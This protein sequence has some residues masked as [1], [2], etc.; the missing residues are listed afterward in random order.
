MTTKGTKPSAEKSLGLRIPAN[1]RQMPQRGFSFRVEDFFNSQ[2]VA[3]VNPATGPR[4]CDSCDFVF[5]SHLPIAGPGSNQALE[6]LQ[7]LGKGAAIDYFVGT[8]T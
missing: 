8:G 5:R 6:L 3:I 4:S 2:K 7:M 1:N